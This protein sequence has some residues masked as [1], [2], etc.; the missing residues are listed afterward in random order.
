MLDSLN[1]S[2]LDVYPPHIIDF[3]KR[4][5]RYNSNYIYTF[6]YKGIHF[7]YYLL[8]HTL[9]FSTHT[10]RILSKLNVVEDDVD[11]YLEKL[12]SIIREVVTIKIPKLNLTRCDYCIDVSTSSSEELKEI[13]NLLQLHHSQFKYIRVN[14]IYDN[15]RYLC[16][17]NSSIN[18]N[19][20]DKFAQ[21]LNTYGYEDNRFKNVLRVELQLKKNK[22]Q[23]LYHKFNVQR[24][25]R[26]YWSKEMLQ[27]LYID[28][29]E[30]YLYK[31]RLL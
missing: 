2:M 12:T 17:P 21:I 20:Y 19:I 3:K 5:R 28:Y 7:N 13:F 24:D 14:Q 30:E 31:R 25:V 27:K 9:T 15:S 23:K 22:I 1:Y 26:K 18:I 11:V 29:L 4:F 16:T 10:Q 6:T 8:H